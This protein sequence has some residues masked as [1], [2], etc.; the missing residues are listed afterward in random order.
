MTATARDLLATFSAL[1]PSEQREV[2][3]EILRRSAGSEGLS[4]QAFEQLAGELFQ[5]YDAEEATGAQR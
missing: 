5:G 1:D 2:A 3:A 4:D